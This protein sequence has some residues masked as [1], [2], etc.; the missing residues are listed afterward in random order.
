MFHGLGL[1][2]ASKDL[3]NVV[4]NIKMC[5]TNMTPWAYRK[6][7]TSFLPSNEWQ[8]LIFSCP[9]LTTYILSVKMMGMPRKNNCKLP[10]VF[11]DSYINKITAHKELFSSKLY[12]MWN[13]VLRLTAYLHTE[14]VFA[15]QTPPNKGF[16][17]PLFTSWASFAVCCWHQRPTHVRSTGS[18]SIKTTTNCNSLQEGTKGQSKCSINCNQ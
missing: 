1:T 13:E 12:S 16:Q 2:L 17:H 8:A 11:Q 18:S 6:D 7:S 9:K 15:L 3:D 4:K 10:E 5:N 14:H